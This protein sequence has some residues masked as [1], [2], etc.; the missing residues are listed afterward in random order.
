MPSR[1]KD[2]PPKE[3]PT[4]EPFALS[5]IPVDGESYCG[6]LHRLA[7]RNDGV[8]FSAILSL[9]GTY[10]GVHRLDPAILQRLSMVSGFAPAVLDKRLGAAPHVGH[11]KVHFGLWSVP[12]TTSRVCPQCLEEA[13]IHRQIW[14][15][16]LVTVCPIHGCPIISNC[17]GC[18]VALT[19]RRSRLTECPKGDNLRLRQDR[20]ASKDLLAATRHF[21]D[22][23]GLGRPWGK[24]TIHGEVAS[25]SNDDFVILV[26]RVALLV[27]K[28]EAFRATAGSATQGQKLVPHAGSDTGLKKAMEIVGDWP[29][30]V[31]ELL[32]PFVAPGKTFVR[33]PKLL[34]WLRDNYLGDLSREAP[35]PYR[36]IKSILIDVAA[37]LGDT[38]SLRR[39][40]DRDGLATI[41]EIGRQTGLTRKII[42]E[43][44]SKQEWETS[45]RVVGK[46]SHVHMILSDVEAWLESERIITVAQAG[47]LLGLERNSVFKLLRMGLLGPD[48]RTPERNSQAILKRSDVEALLS[49]LR[50]QRQGP[51]KVTRYPVATC[52]AVP[53]E[54]G[55]VGN[56]SVPHMIKA[57]AD[58]WLR[59]WGEPD[60]PLQWH[61][62]EKDFEGLPRKRRSRSLNGARIAGIP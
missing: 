42:L 50:R 43:A 21:C 20:A 13:P 53:R 32:A 34:S 17:P 28:L 41:E 26:R 33:E 58:G 56:R 48:V 47:R 15:H 23:V 16:R 39:H 55:K 51:A 38:F 25:L 44:A 52:P 31:G 12:P 27:D 8:S 2:A 5:A 4:V 60:A 35:A 3:L 18:G 7:Q 19:W 14:Q 62:H 1:K 6:F 61:F 45:V 46:Q 49:L 22:R 11:S 24:P 54:N 59:Y 10:P 57:V 29:T 30:G 40:M 9:I 36:L 37:E